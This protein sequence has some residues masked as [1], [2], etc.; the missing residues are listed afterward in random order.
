MPEQTE[1]VTP[2]VADYA[3]ILIVKLFGERAGKAAKAIAPAALALVAVAVQWLA[4]G[5]Y[6][7]A[8]LATT[9]LGI[10]GPLVT[11]LVPNLSTVVRVID[12]AKAKDTISEVKLPEAAVVKAAKGEAVVVGSSA[13]PPDGFDEPADVPFPS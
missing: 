8:E 12:S 9:I 10:G 11:Y 2:S 6:D 13:D 3:L 4:T 1:P 5:K 7:A